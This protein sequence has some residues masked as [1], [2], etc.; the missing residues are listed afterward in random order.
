VVAHAN[1]EASL[2]PP[3]EHR[4]EKSLPGEEEECGNRTNM[5]QAHEGS[6]YPVDFVVGGWLTM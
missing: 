2:N 3:Q 4:H 6:G 5:K 1:A